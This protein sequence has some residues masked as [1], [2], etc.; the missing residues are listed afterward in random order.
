MKHGGGTDFNAV[1]EHIHANGFKRIVFIT[2][3]ECAYPDDFHVT[4]AICSEK[5]PEER[6][7]KLYDFGVF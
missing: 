2:D 4:V 7:D 5:F 3:G 1:F 6:C